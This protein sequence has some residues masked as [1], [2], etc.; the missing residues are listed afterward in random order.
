MGDDDQRQLAVEQER[1]QPVGHLGIQ[2]VGRLV[3]QQQLGARQQEPGQRRAALLATR[4]I[5]AARVE[6]G[7]AERLQQ[8]IGAVVDIVATELLQPCIEPLLFGQQLVEAR[9]RLVLGQFAV[10][11]LQGL[12]HLVA[13]RNAPHHR[14]VHGEVRLQ[15]RFLR[16]VTKTQLA[17]HRALAAVRHQIGGEDAQQGRLAATVRTEQADPLTVADD[18]R[19]AL[20]QVPVPDGDVHVLE[21]QQSHRQMLADATPARKRGLRSPPDGTA[22]AAYRRAARAAPPAALRGAGV[23]CRRASSRTSTHRPGRP[24]CRRR[25]AASARS[26]SRG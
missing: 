3:E 6:L 13:P 19:Q 22:A 20:Q 17:A 4:Q 2:V 10:Q 15:Q 24:R 16:Q 1:L 14:L 12:Q 25:P 21:R 7:H 26:G 9:R 8:R 5:G 23:R 11:R 18:H